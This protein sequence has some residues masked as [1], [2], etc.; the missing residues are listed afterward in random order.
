MARAVARHHHERF[1]GMG[2]PAGLNGTEVPLAARLVTVAHAY[3][4]L[5]SARSYRLALPHADTVQRMSEMF[6]HQMDPALLAAFERCEASFATTFS[7]CLD[8]E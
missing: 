4:D 3:D 1:D 7:D 5:R 8:G 6:G 2:C